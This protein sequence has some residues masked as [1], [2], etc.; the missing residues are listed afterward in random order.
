MSKKLSLETKIRDAA[1]SLSKANAS[2]RSVSKQ[3]SEQL[4]AAN[5]KVDLAQKE[6]WRVSERAN[7]IQRRL[8]EHRAGVLSYSIRSMERQASPNPYSLPPLPGSNG[9]SSTS[10]S[11]TPARSSLT[12][13]PSSVTSVQT[14]ASARFEHFFAGHADTVVPQVPR[15][16]PTV[17]EIRALEDK[18]RAAAAA[19][20]EAQE[21][22]TEATRE[23]AMLRLEKEQVETSLG[24]DLQAAEDTISVLERDVARME[25]VE[26]QLR[27]L[28]EE[29]EEWLQERAELEEKRREVDLLERRLEVLEERSGEATEIE[30][31]LARERAERAALL[32][33]K[34]RQLE[35]VR[36]ALEAERAAWDIER[37]T[38]QEG[39]DSQSQLEEL[40][41][42]LH[43]VMQTHNVPLF[44]GQTSLPGL[45]TSIQKHL[46]DVHSRLDEHERAQAE[47]MIT[48]AKME[49]DLRI[50]LDKREALFAEIQ[51]VRT[52]RDEAKAQIKQLEA[53]LKVCSMRI[54]SQ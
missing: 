47:W 53:Q 51:E 32:A 42:M 9:D 13:P 1:L 5:R 33:E 22:H 15:P 38:L 14:T 35:E 29:R 21:K 8:L 48:K 28:E 34:E 7:E 27:A 25:E 52:A 18:A 31:V 37:A 20:A 16:P 46:E 45:V 26:A 39:G 11:S 19:L 2:Y 4:D 10:G 41:D 23:L 40:S 54:F 49:E 12:S 36:Q 30:G 50:G 3:T 43:E 6:L 24:M 44:S 17:V